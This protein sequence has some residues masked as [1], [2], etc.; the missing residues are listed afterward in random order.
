[1]RDKNI[2]H[3]KKNGLIKSIGIGIILLALAISGI[4]LKI[5]MDKT[6]ENNKY[7]ELISK[8]TFDV[9]M[10]DE[11]INECNSLVKNSKYLSHE[12]LAEL[13]SNLS[14]LYTI[15][16]QYEKS[17]DYTVSSLNYANK[18]SRHDILSKSMNNLA[19]IFLELQE[20]DVAE[21]IFLNLFNLEIEDLGDRK[22]N[23]EYAIINLAE[24][25]S[26]TNRDDKAIEILQR[27]FK[28]TDGVSLKPD[29]EK[30][31][32]TI[33][34]LIYARAYFNKGQYDKSEETLK[35]INVEIDST[36]QIWLLNVVTNYLSI[37]A[38]LEMCAGR[39]DE[40]K[41]T[42]KKFIEVCDKNGYKERKVYFFNE[43]Y[44]LCEKLNRPF[45]EEYKNYLLHIYPKMLTQQNKSMG[46][47]IIDKNIEVLDKVKRVDK[48]ILTYKKVAI[49]GIFIVLILYILVDNLLKANRNSRI[50]ALTNIN[51]RRYFD[52]IY[53]KYKASNCRYGFIIIDID[54]FKK[55]NDRY[56]HEFGDYVLK[57]VAENMKNNIRKTDKIFRYGGEEF[58]VLCNAN[59]K[60]N[61]IDLAERLRKNI[62]D[63]RLENG[64]NVTISLGI[65]YS[66]EEKELFL[67]ADRNLYKSK[68]NGKNRVTG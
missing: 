56:G 44:L 25:Y 50:D 11:L 40:S 37:K 24:V 39:H 29:E 4:A 13:Y 63:M 61:I 32:G 9:N 41:S 54:D 2:W 8:F 42:I 28:D 23:R 67:V 14:T 58:C 65:A 27:K 38:R 17:I 12:Q 46:N 22:L 62:E 66:D 60:D 57:S 18:M 51:N 64:I 6:D 30:M 26:R 53:E 35:K 68:N 43:I 52:K 19:N 59:A 20:Y 33:K 3:I 16:R 31:I 21:E 10:K 47:F 5:H 55:I 48:T 15:N 49:V 36:D 45:P 34:W 7:N 1:M